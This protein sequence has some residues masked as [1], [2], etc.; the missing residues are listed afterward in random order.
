MAPQFFLYTIHQVISPVLVPSVEPNILEVFLW[1]Q[2]VRGP[3]TVKCHDCVEK[4]RKKVSRR[5]FLVTAHHL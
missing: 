3:V 2:T 1:Y 5:G 4:E